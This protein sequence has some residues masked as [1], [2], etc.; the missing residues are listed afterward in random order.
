M[1]DPSVWYPGWTYPTLRGIYKPAPE[2][3]ED[4][5]LLVAFIAQG[6]TDALSK[7]FEMKGSFPQCAGEVCTWAD[8]INRGKTGEAVKWWTRAY[9]AGPLP[10]DEEFVSPP[11]SPA[12]AWPD[13]T[14]TLERRIYAWRF[15]GDNLYKAMEIQ[16]WDEKEQRWRIFNKWGQNLIWTAKNSQWE[17]GWDLGD[18]VSQRR[19]D[20]ANAIWLGFNAIISIVTLGAGAAI[21]ASYTAAQAAQQA[22]V[23][24]MKKAFNGDAAGAAADFGKTITAIAKVNI[25]PE[26]LPKFNVDTKN[27]LEDLS[28]IGPFQKV[29]ALV[30]DAKTSDPLKLLE[31]ASKLGGAKFLNVT[32]NDIKAIRGMFP[33]PSTTYYFDLGRQYAANIVNANPPWYAAGAFNLGGILE[34]ALH[35]PAVGQRGS[36]VRQILDEALIRQQ[37][38]L[39]KLVEISSTYSGNIYATDAAKREALLSALRQWARTHQTSTGPQSQQYGPITATGKR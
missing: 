17:A 20:I 29:A 33:A 18:W 25:P 4:L 21:A 19:A 22:W 23:E 10:E 14:S 12:Y 16:K 24:G 31:S 35:A 36:R 11:G 37:A 2:T 1:A 5:E 8:F 27:A 34:T 6:G 7:F 26:G 39:L 28:K 13:A 3:A 9:Q 15:D 32:E 30:A 38:D